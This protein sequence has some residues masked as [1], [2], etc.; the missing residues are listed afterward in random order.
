[1]RSVYL[2]PRACSEPLG[3]DLRASAGRS[4][5]ACFSLRV[6]SDE[7]KGLAGV[8]TQRRRRWFPGNVSSRRRYQSQGLEKG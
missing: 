4:R 1:M 3:S 5:R 6:L 2:V 8:F 7:G